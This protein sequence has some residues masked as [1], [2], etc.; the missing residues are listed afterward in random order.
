MQ[1]HCPFVC[2]AY[3]LGDAQSLPTWS[4]RSSKVADLQ[5]R[6]IRAICDVRDSKVHDFIRAHHSPWDAQAALGGCRQVMCPEG[7]V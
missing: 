1:L 3:T 5:R 2:T 4:R 6:K 7:G